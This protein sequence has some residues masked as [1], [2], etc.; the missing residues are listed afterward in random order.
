MSSPGSLRVHELH[1]SIDRSVVRRLSLHRK[2]LVAAGTVALVGGLAAVLLSVGE[3]LA[4]SSA[5]GQ[6]PTLGGEPDLNAWVL[7][8]AVV[9]IAPAVQT[10]RHAAA[11]RLRA[12]SAWL[13]AAL[14]AYAGW[15]ILIDA[16]VH[17]WD[18]LMLLS[19]ARSPDPLVARL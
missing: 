5:G 7:T 11:G 17:G 14:V 6:N 8:L 18:D 10:I 9:G 4:A 2:L 1:G 3:L 15:A 12:A 13:S 19:C 16:A